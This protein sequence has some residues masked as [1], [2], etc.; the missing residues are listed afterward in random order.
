MESNVLEAVWLNESGQCTMVH[1]AE[2]SGLNSA[3][4]QSLV[5]SGVLSP[6]PAAGD[7]LAFSTGAMLVV[8]TARRLRDDFELSP[9]GLALAMQLLERIHELD[10]ELERVRAGL[11][12]RL[13]PS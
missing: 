11:A 3:E 8:R 5:D 12:G 7:T 1:L 10:H 13:P 9:V 4:L 2:V 6:L